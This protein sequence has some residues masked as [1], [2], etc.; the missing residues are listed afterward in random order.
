VGVKSVVDVEINTAEFERFQKLF[1]RYQAA[2]SKQ[3]ASWAKV[4]KAVEA[5]RSGFEAIMA[6]MLAQQALSQK[7]S[8]AEDEEERKLSRF[9]RTWGRIA[10]HSKT[11]TRNVTDMAK[12]VLRW[13]SLSTIT[14]GLV[15]AGS[16]FGLDRLAG[17]VASG[18]R[19]A[20]GVGAGYG[21]YQAFGATFGRFV[22]PD[23]FLSG[24]GEA[25]INPAL[26]PYLGAIG[27]T[28]REQ[29]GTTGQ[30]AVRALQ[31]LKGLVDRTP[32][33]QLALLLQS[34]GAGNL[35]LTDQDLRRL[36]AIPRSELESQVRT[37][38]PRARALEFDDRT[39]RAWN[40]FI[41][42]LEIAGKKIESAFVTGLDPL[43]KSGALDKLSDGFANAVKTFASSPQLQKWM[44]QLASGVQLFAEYI[45][46]DKFQKDVRTFVEDI[47]VIAEAAA[48]LAKRI[49]DLTSGPPPIGKPLPPGTQFVPNAPSFWQR[50]HIVPNMGVTPGRVLPQGANNV[51]N[52]RVPGS[53]QFQS[54]ATQ[55]E[56]IRAVAR[57]LSLYGDR[58]RLSTIRQIITKY[59][60]PSE[61]DTAAYIKAVSARM[62]VAPDQS[63]NLRDKATMAALVSAITKQEGRAKGIT[64]QVVIKVLD[65]TGGNVNVTASSLAGR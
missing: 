21:E 59:A 34:T 35:G 29:Q 58:D 9:E 36:R 18:R 10:Q 42:Q 45:S 39:L 5:Q 8:R 13:T 53:L 37:F 62:G 55:D 54:F 57:Q 40:D 41:N 61:N 30:V 60:P 3:P 7:R 50:W 38:G 51:G 47:G 27:L 12:A 19:G 64:P 11:I 56:G 2:L 26:R 28:G 31:H 24:V 32:L 52:L 6:T 17:A 63:L 44:E 23:S 46:S 48:A 33:D 4:N 16:L 20:L 1:E 22:N 49:G 25:L 43:I 15:G 14:L 65:N